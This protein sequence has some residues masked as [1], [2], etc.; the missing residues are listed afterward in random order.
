MRAQSPLPGAAR[1]G[2]DDVARDLEA[3][4][5]EIRVFSRGLHPA[6]LARAGL[7]PSLRELARRPPIPVDLDVTPLGRLPQRVSLIAPRRGYVTLGPG[8]L[9]SRPSALRLASGGGVGGHLEEVATNVGD[10]FQFAAQGSDVA[11]KGFDG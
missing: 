6:L 2:L 9:E 3:V 5:E 1:A 7:D 8:Q 11:G 10:Q 4:L